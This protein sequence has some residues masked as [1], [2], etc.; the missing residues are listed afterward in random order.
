VK[1][2]VLCRSG[3]TSQ[4]TQ[5][6]TEFRRKSGVSKAF[7]FLACGGQEKY[8]HVGRRPRLLL[9]FRLFC[10]YLLID[11]GAILQSRTGAKETGISGTYF[12]LA[13]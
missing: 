8:S 12:E 7:R 10:F 11:S 9:S 3:R 2:L 1:K 13:K 4:G 5:V 6:Y